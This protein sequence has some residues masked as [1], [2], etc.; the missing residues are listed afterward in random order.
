MNRFKTKKKGAKED[1]ADARPSLESESSF[2][3]FRRGKKNS[4]PETKKEEIDLSSALPSND[5]FRTSLIMNGLSAR[6]SMLR[7]QDD[8]NSKIGKAS[9]DSVLFPKR[10]SRFADFGFTSGKGLGDI[11]EDESIKPPSFLRKDSNAS[12][13][14]S[15]MTRSRPMESNVLFGGRQKVYKVATS[16]NPGDGISGR[17]LYDG[18]VGTSSFQKWRLAEKDKEQDAS[19]EHENHEDDKGSSDRSPEESSFI[20]RPESPVPH[21]YNKKRETSSTTSSTPSVGRN[22]TAATS[23]ISQPTAVSKEGSSSPNSTPALERHVTRTRKLYEQGLNQNLQDQQHSVLTRVDTLA[24]RPGGVRTP[25]LGPNTPSPTTQ[26][27]NDRWAAFGSER[28]TISTKGSAPNLRSVSPTTA[29]GSPAIGSL[30]R[31]MTLNTRVSDGPDAKGGLFMSP[32]LSPPI[33]DAGTGEHVNL[34]IQARDLGKATAMNVF[35]KPIS[36]YDDSKYAERM[37]QLQQGRETPN[38]KFRD[39]MNFSI[40]D[41]HS[42]PAAATIRQDSDKTN[43]APRSSPSQADAP[44]QSDPNELTFFDATMESP[45]LSEHPPQTPDFR[46]ERPSDQDHPAFRSMT[47]PMPLKFPTTGEP[48]SSGSKT[49]DV[50]SAGPRPTMLADSPTL[51]PT[52]GGLSGLVRQHLRTE[53]DVSSVYG[54]SPQPSPRRQDSS[55]NSRDPLQGLDSIES[56]TN[57]DDRNLA[58]PKSTMPQTGLPTSGL[59]RAQGTFLDSARSPDEET[60]FADQLANARRRVREKLTSFVE[61]DPSYSYSPPM[62]ADQAAELPP[63]PSRSNPLGILRGKGSRGSLI[64][65]GRDATRPTR[66][67]GLGDETEKRLN[68]EEDA[69]PSLRAFRQVRREVQKRKELEAGMAPSMHGRPLMTSPPIDE[70]APITNGGRREVPRTPSGDRQHVAPRHPRHTTREIPEDAPSPPPRSRSRAARDRSGSENS[71]GSNRSRSRPPPRARDHAHPPP[72]P[73]EVAYDQQPRR[74]V[75][76]SPCLPGTDIR[77]S[78]ILPPMNSRNGLR[79][80]AP[81]PFQGGF[82]DPANLKS[83]PGRAMTE[84]LSSAPFTSTPRT[85]RTEQP[86]AFYPTNSAPRSAPGS[87]T[88]TPTLPPSRR[89]SVPANPYAG[90]SGSTLT[91]AMKRSINKKDISEPTFVMS[92]H[93]VPTTTLPQDAR[94]TRSRSG[95]V[96]NSGSPPPLPPVDPR[97]KRNNSRSR[98]LMSGIMGG[99][100]SDESDQAAFSMSTPQLPLSTPPMP[101]FSDLAAEDR[102][103]AYSVVDDDETRPSRR[104]LRKASSELR[105]DQAA[106]MLNPTRVSPPQA[107]IGP[108]AGRAVMVRGGPSANMNGG[109]F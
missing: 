71:D 24:R 82:N 98:A 69:H 85:G 31:T 10:Q 60:E 6:F 42:H 100:R 89:P 22:S 94:S 77:G 78:P 44:A 41:S 93:R 86:R 53:S 3:L 87:G 17:V 81:G 40:P 75:V 32:P 43:T 108:P 12:C 105:L 48:Q 104:R 83:L 80:A 101:P 79:S 72:I 91:D 54:Q 109:M 18:D 76:R 33:S 50:H 13:D 11:A 99:R 84:P 36:P 66:E 39:D 19:D 59:S 67:S 61:T 34:H 25:E 8:P 107:A 45:I 90:V 51:G 2:S 49:P 57:G 21:G 64:D 88:S 102:N 30:N 47:A 28:R 37:R 1:V 56:R 7:E 63:P 58:S 55:P 26:T 46:L 38:Q 106:S 23:I 15:I 4:E 70:H 5:D 29:I 92:T 35:Q 73:S 14:S 95:S 52:T 103:T 16:K 97:R 27:F 96:A 65:R 62:I 68:E 74:P 20:T 9:D